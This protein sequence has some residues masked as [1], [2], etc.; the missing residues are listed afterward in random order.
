MAHNRKIVIGAVSLTM[1]RLPRYDVLAM[2][3]AADDVE[4]LMQELGYL[5]HAPFK[6]VGLILRLGLKNEDE[7]HYKPI[8]PKDG[9]LP[10]AI[11]LDTHELRAAS[12]EELRRKFTLV[13]L[14]ALIHAG[15]KF[16]LPTAR[17]EER[18]Y[19]LTESV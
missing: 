18:Y 4:G 11:E 3:D 5:E 8:D 12:S 17:L 15:R 16:D 6:W 10:L 19:Q 7:P 14:T 2:Q 1:A 13:A 9:E